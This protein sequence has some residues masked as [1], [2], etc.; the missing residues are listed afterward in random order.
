MAGKSVDAKKPVTTVGTDIGKEGSNMAK[1]DGSKGG[2]ATKTTAKAKGAWSKGKTDSK[3][4]KQISKDVGTGKGGCC[5]KTEAL[6]QTLASAQ[7]SLGVKGIDLALVGF[8]AEV[9]LDCATSPVT[10]AFVQCEDK[11]ERVWSA[12]CL[13]EFY[14]MDKFN[15]PSPVFKK[16]YTIRESFLQE[17]WDMK[18]DPGCLTYVRD[19][20]PNIADEYL[21]LM[22]AVITSEK[23]KA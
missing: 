10:E 17:A 20:V 9:I 5:S 23:G 21:Q 22:A 19:I 11:E 12:F 1:G 16:N 2:K 15:I 13:R 8:P 4:P 3:K 14:N 7:R 6:K 18:P